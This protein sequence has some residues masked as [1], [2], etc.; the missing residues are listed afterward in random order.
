LLWL[1]CW[2]LK[3]AQNVREGDHPVAREHVRKDVRYGHIRNG[4][5]DAVVLVQHIKEDCLD[6]RFV[7]FRKSEASLHVPKPKVLVKSFGKTGVQGVRHIISHKELAILG[8]EVETHVGFLL[9]E[10]VV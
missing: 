10:V 8:G 5:A 1:G 3:V 9:V 7:V 4:S 2:L 6:F